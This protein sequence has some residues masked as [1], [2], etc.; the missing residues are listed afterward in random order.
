LS[1]DDN[2]FSQKFIKIESARIETENSAIEF[3]TW[4]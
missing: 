2:N 3:L 4:P 1:G